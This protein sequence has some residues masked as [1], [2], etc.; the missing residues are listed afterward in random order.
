VLGEHPSGLALAGA[1]SIAVGVFV[2]TGDP[3]RLRG[4]RA[5]RSV[6]FALLTGV[7]I[8]AYTLWDKQ[9]VSA[10]HIAPLL[11]FWGLTTARAILLTPLGVARWQTV[12][13]EWMSHRREAFG[14]AVLSGVAY[15]LVLIA[16]TVTPVSY[17]APTREIG[18]LIG[19]L[20]GSR[21]LAEGD[22]SRRLAG[23]G[24]MVVGVVALAVG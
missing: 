18:I 12:R 22:A 20:M 9:A 17:V 14:I 23:A 7:L 16:L 3:R 6:V 1:A 21:W 4:Q 13:Q 24:A 8:A 19:A 10:V 2:L 5:G 11:Y 15:V